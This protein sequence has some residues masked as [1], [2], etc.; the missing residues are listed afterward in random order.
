M[1]RHISWAA[2]CLAAISALA[3]YADRRVGAEYHPFDEPSTALRAVEPVTPGWGHTVTLPVPDLT[4]VI[5][6]DEVRD[7]EGKA[8]RWGILR[9]LPAPI[10]VDAGSPAWEPLPDGRWRWTVQLRLPG[11]L[12]VRAAFAVDHAP[13]GTL[14]AVWQPDDGTPVSATP[15]PESTPEGQPFW[16][17][18]VFEDGMIAGLLLPEGA[19]PSDVKASVVRAVHVYRFAPA[20]VRPKEAGCHNDT[21]CHPEWDAASRSVAGIG[22]VSSGIGFL[23]CTGCLIADG[24][25]GTKVPYF[26][27]AN[28]CVSGPAEADT[29]ETYWLFR[30]ETCNGSAPAVASVPRVSGG[31]D[32]LAGANR[33]SGTD[34]ALLRLRG[35]PP[36]GTVFSGWSSA[37]LAAGNPITGIH[38]P[39]GSYQRISFG[40][41]VRP[42]SRFWSV[43]W[44][45]GVTEPGSSGS[46]LFNG[47][48]EFIGQL[49]GG[50]SSCFFQRGIDEYG[51]FDITYPSVQQYLDTPVAADAGGLYHFDDP[52]DF[53][54]DGVSDQAVF[55]LDGSRWYLNKS[56]DGFEDFVFGFAGVIAASGDIDGDG[57][58][59]P[60]AYHPPSG[61]WYMFGSRD[62]FR[63]TQFGYE[64]TV[65]VPG[66]YDNDGTTDIAVFEPARGLWFIYQSRDGFRFERFGFEGT[67]AV[68]ADYDGDGK[69]DLCVV[70]PSSARWYVYGS[71]DRFD[72]FLLGDAGTR[73]LAG[74]YD[75]DGRADQAACNPATAVWSFRGS[76]AGE[77]TRTVGQAGGIP[78]P[79]DYDGDGTDDPCVYHLADGTWT[80]IGSTSGVRQVQFG[81]SE[82]PPVGYRAPGL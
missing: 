33:F 5:R 54:G 20:L 28:H 22:S 55:Y 72:T 82:A 75:G 30:T 67:R 80:I 12:G 60:I 40:N 10:P 47:S 81:W 44:Y 41:V 68:P 38:H 39:D 25:P 23:F 76:T 14:L 1:Q 62:G 13:D 21:A 43:R 65:P 24:D 46:P 34:F 18:S 59:D 45:S 52:R 3:V 56:R 29:I 74:D 16:S 78:V 51:R 63:T 2:C 50:V 17:G 57:A 53:D 61:T 11:A 48:M 58:S 31:A 49:Y 70:D 42:G 32:F 36:A 35:N 8:Y 27:T 4:E 37:A 9:S 19:S 15:L 66:D 64:G 26:M 7:R 71:T 79:G 77:W 73:Y 6:E 69:T